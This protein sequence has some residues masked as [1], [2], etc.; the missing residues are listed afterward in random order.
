MN[1]NDLQIPFYF[2]SD[3]AGHLTVQID[4][5]KID[6]GKGFA[7][8]FKDAAV[9]NLDRNPG[10]VGQTAGILGTRRL[11][12]YHMDRIDPHGDKVFNRLIFFGGIVLM[13]QLDRL[14]ALGLGNRLE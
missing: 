1:P 8:G 3:A 7:L 13:M 14:V 9:G 2:F 11:N 6:I 12:R 10:F 5:V 4:P